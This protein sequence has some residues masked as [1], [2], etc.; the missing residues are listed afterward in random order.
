ME[1]Q[2]EQLR[3]DALSEL[4]SAA[5]EA[6]VLSHLAKLRGMLDAAAVHKDDPRWI[7]LDQLVRQQGAAIDREPGG[8]S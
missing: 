1:T 7:G 3:T 6:A 5:D 4:A 8:A 2:L